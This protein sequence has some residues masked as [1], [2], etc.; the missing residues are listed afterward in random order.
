MNPE[1]RKLSWLIL[2][3]P[4][5]NRT[6]RCS[7]STYMAKMRQRTGERSEAQEGFYAIGNIC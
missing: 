1:G 6:P 5:E 4:Q 7:Q 2:V 3:S